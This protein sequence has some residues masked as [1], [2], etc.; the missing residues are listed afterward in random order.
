MGNPTNIAHLGK[1]LPQPK[2]RLTADEFISLAQGIIES[3]EIIRDL[4]GLNPFYDLEDS[5]ATYLAEIM[6]ERKGINTNRRINAH[7]AREYL[8]RTI[9]TKADLELVMNFLR[10]KAEN[11]LAAQQA[12]KAS[13]E[14]ISGLR[15]LFRRFLHFK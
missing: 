3:E 7:Q 9:Q 10:H 2:K 1:E 6:M 4:L 12:E 5:D 15:G 13:R 8:K 11:I 14:E